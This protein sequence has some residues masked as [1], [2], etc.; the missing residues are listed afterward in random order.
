MITKVTRSIWTLK[1]DGLT[2][3]AYRV[4]YAPKDSWKKDRIVSY[5]WTKNLPQTVLDFILNAGNVET[6]YV[7]EEQHS[8]GIAGLK[9]ETYTA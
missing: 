7:P 5:N 8:P 3:W 4:H 1:A 6:R 9:Q 2:Y